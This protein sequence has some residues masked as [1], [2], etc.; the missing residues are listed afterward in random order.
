MTFLLRFALFAILLGAACKKDDAPC[1]LAARH[2]KQTSP[3]ACAQSTWTFTKRADGAWDAKETG[4][5]NAT[6]IARYDG[7]T[8]VVDFQYEGGNAKGR[9]NW[10]VDGACKGH[11]GTVSWSAGSLKGQSA[12]TTLLAE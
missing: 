8:V 11:A 3:G 4:C 5:A 10:P 9:Y 7:T 6:G 12:A 1:D 2:W